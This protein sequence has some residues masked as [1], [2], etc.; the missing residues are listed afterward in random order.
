[1]SA[2]GGGL[3]TSCCSM[4][5]RYRWCTCVKSGYRTMANAVAKM[6]AKQFSSCA[7]TYWLRD[8]ISSR[9]S[10]EIVAESVFFEC[11]DCDRK[12]CHDPHVL[13]ILIN[14][15]T[16]G[17]GLIW[18]SWQHNENCRMLYFTSRRRQGCCGCDIKQLSN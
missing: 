9:R 7:S 13:S 3:S 1:M 4:V 8:Y 6:Y 12:L 10:S 17:F 11:D 15:Q 16:P 18:W 14:T 5:V 2:T